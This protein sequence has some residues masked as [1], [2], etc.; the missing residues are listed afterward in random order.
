MVSRGLSA[1]RGALP[2]DLEGAS[3][4]TFDVGF[5][6]SPKGGRR[7]RRRPPARRCLGSRRRTLVLFTKLPH[8]GRVKT[9]LGRE[10]GAVAATRIA[11]CLLAATV[12]A[13]ARDRRWRTVLAVTPD[14]ARHRRWTRIAGGPR[15]PLTTVGQGSGDLGRRMAR[16][17][18]DHARPQAVLIGSDIP[19]LTPRDVATAFAA[20]GRARFVVGPATDGGYWLIGWRRLGGWP[21]GAFADV[22]WSSPD[23]LADTLASLPRRC[24]VARIATRAD[25]DERADLQTWRALGLRW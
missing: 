2:P 18:R 20:L 6:F 8:L 4:T 14:R 21:P 16:A 22:R 7:R 1:V 23:A 5:G 10:V 19:A 25:L 24:P 11:R 9:R 12:R 17:L 3:A 15:R 13:L